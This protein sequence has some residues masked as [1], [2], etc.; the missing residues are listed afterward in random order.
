MD[1]EEV[2]AGFGVVS[3][4]FL[5]LWVVPRIKAPKKLR[6]YVRACASI[7]RMSANHRYVRTKSAYYWVYRNNLPR[8]VRLVVDTLLRVDSTN[9]LVD[10]PTR[11]SSGVEI[12]RAILRGDNEDTDV[13]STL[14]EQLHQ[15]DAPGAIDKISFSAS[16]LLPLEYVCV[17]DD[18]CVVDVTFRGYSNPEKRIPAKNYSVRY[19][20]ACGEV[21][22]FPPY[23]VHEKQR[24]GFGVRKIKKVEVQAP[25]APDLTGRVLSWAGPRHNF[26]EDCDSSGVAK[27]YIDVQYDTEVTYSGGGSSDGSKMLLRV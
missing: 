20:L 4:T 12:K 17:V 13:T 19:D 15:L 3:A 11:P 18:P 22:E 27:K 9:A 21:A 5:L 26:Y 2:L 16:D 23:G 6:M 10:N 14:A 8:I 7:V 24:K 1:T 25:D